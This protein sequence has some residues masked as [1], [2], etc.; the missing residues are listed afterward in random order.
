MQASLYR[1]WLPGAVMEANTILVFNKISTWIVRDVDHMQAKDISLTWHVQHTLRQSAF[2]C[3]VWSCFSF[4]VVG[5]WGRGSF[6]AIVA[7][8]WVACPYFTFKVPTEPNCGLTL[9]CTDWYLPAWMEC[10]VGELS[11]PLIPRFAWIK[12]KKSVQT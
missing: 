5:G 4:N 11:V 10:W 2:S 7:V 9:S 6:G 12:K 8:K 3:T 1:E